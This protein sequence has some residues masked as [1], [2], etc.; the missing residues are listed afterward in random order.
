MKRS[1]LYLLISQIYLVGSFI[2]LS[3]DF[4]SWCSCLIASILWLITSIY[5]G[6]EER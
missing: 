3:L 5:A 1:E 6:I 4:S 2:S